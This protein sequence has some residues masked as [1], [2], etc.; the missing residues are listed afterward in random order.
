MLFLRIK[1][2]E[3]ALADGRL[4]EAF[5]LAMAPDVRRHRQGQR[6]VSR[7]M[8]A[9]VARGQDHLAGGRYPQAM[10]D[11]NR[12]EQL[13]G[14]LPPIAELK[15]AAARAAEKDHQRHR[16]RADILGQARAYLDHG[17]LSMGERVLG[18]LADPDSQARVLQQHAERRRMEMESVL[19]R[20]RSAVEREEWKDAV[21]YLL[22][23][24][25]IQAGHEELAEL[26]VQVRTALCRELRVAVE[27]GR[28]DRTEDLLPLVDGLAGEHP[29][30]REWGRILGQLR[31]A[32]TMIGMGRF[33]PAGRMLR[34]LAAIL[35]LAAWM[36]DVVAACAQGAQAM[37][38]L[39]GGPLGLW[40]IED[41]R[42]LGNREGADGV[43]NDESSVR[44]GPPARV[45]GG[46][47]PSR[48]ILRIDGAGGL[49]VVRNSPI[50]I[51]PVSS[52]LPPDVGLVAD[53]NMPGV[54]LEREDG[55]YFLK[56]GDGSRRLLAHGDTVE[57]GPRCRMKFL[58]PH[59]ASSSAVLRLEGVRLA[60][61]DVRQV[62]L[63]DREIVIGAGASNHVRVDGV[64][65]PMVL[66]VNDGRLVW[67]SRGSSEGL[68][69]EI[70]LNEPVRVGPVSLIVI[71]A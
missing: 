10:A 64:A 56:S 37:E 65:E 70:P 31:E 9:L 42:I 32:W 15:S 25:S 51:G 60:H 40:L 43:R 53:P 16:L 19:K 59:P 8:A 62:I 55:D 44:D 33:G 30:V 18:E 11:G 29:E 69:K 27:Q 71:P 24:K 35:P 2:A 38:T 12:A 63:M 20:A 34:P 3:T 58:L 66:Y 13:G 7:L 39:A 23:A 4:D 67:R 36:N 41:P 61:G 50:T 47:L 21:D 6:L 57:V 52:S 54:T 5:D 26:V 14:H 68:Q 22:K 49:L 17:Q 48:F 46:R 1:Q 45:P 28:I